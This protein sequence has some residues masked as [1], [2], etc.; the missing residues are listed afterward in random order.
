MTPKHLL[1]GLKRPKQIEF[2]QDVSSPGYAKFIAEPFERGFGV[3]IGNSLRRTLM[4]TIEG[5]AITAVKIEGVSHEFATLGGLVEDITR[6]ILNIKQVRITYDTENR[7]EPK[8]LHV[9]KS[10]KSEVRCHYFPELYKPRKN[11]EKK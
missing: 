3:T 2:A 9:E 6:L 1:R 8:I 5:A 4:S 11:M 7:D 10:R